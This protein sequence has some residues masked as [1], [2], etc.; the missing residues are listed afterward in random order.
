MS[1]RDWWDDLERR[2]DMETGVAGSGLA[3]VACALA[4]VLAV[5]VLA[6]LGGAP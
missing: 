1:C 4:I 3:A 2:A 5:V 6:L